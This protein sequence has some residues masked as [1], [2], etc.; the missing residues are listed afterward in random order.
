M[1]KKI[2]TWLIVG[3]FLVGL[4]SAGIISLS[5]WDSDLTLNETSTDRIKAVANIPEIDVEIGK[6]QCDDSECWASLYQ[7][8]LIQTEWRRDK[9]YCSEWAEITNET[10]EQE[11]LTW[12]DYTL[13]ENK[14]AIQD[15][16]EKRLSDWAV[17]EEKRQ[18]KVVEDKT[19]VGVI[20]EKAVEVIK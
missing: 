20:G 5:A 8:D 15:Y 16:L 19:D 13:E 7:E 12:T 3:F 9:S 6:I 14:Q 10:L 1:N 11:C 2:M 18:N 17:V 4:T